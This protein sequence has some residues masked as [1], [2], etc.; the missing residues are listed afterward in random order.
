M[1]G[2]VC[3]PRML[4]IVQPSRLAVVVRTLH[5]VT[6]PAHLSITTIATGAFGASAAFSLVRTLLPA[7]ANRHTT[8][9][10]AGRPQHAMHADDGGFI[11]RERRNPGE[12]RRRQGQVRG[13]NN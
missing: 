1:L 4:H 9:C 12:L 8:E 7:P 6:P 10:F 2:W 5:S 3:A 13:W 11:R